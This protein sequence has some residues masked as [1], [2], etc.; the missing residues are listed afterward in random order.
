MRIFRGKNFNALGSL[1]NTLTIPDVTLRFF[2]INQTS[3]LLM[4]LE[5]E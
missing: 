2:V 4:I 5:K 1:S 3:Q